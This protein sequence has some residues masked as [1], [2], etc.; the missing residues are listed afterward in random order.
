MDF[1]FTLEFWA[2][3]G[4]TPIDDFLDGLPADLTAWLDDKTE[5]FAKSFVGDL[6]RLRFLEKMPGS[7]LYELRYKSSPPV[8]ML[9]IV[10]NKEF[11]AVEA[12][13]KKSGG[14]DRIRASH[15][16]TALSRARTWDANH[17]K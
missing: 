1:L 16:L 3:D 8:R 14:N 15:I 9:C 4:Q 11:I 2:E 13:I 12:L 5:Y 10:R 17:K 6:L 7:P